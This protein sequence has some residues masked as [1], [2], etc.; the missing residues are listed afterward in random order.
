MKPPTMPWI[1]LALLELQRC[2]QLAWFVYGCIER[3][4]RLN[5]DACV[6]WWLQAFTPAAAQPGS[7]GSWNPTPPAR[8]PCEGQRLSAPMQD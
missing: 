6:A 2:Q 3:E 5:L 8:A 7:S 4:H 1:D